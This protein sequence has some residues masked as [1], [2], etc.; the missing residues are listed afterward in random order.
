MNNFDRKVDPPPPGWD[1]F[2]TP[3]AP[4]QAGETK[5]RHDREQGDGSASRG[6]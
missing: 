2:G 4:S 1:V 6:R 3:T 5:E